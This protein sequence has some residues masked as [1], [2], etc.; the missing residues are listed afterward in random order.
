MPSPERL[1]ELASAR[2]PRI[3]LVAPFFIMPGPDVT[4]VLLIRHAQVPEGGIE[5][6]SA[7]TDLGKEQAEVL[8][9]YLASQP[10]AA[11]YASP[12]ARAIATATPVASRQGLQIE[13]LDGLRDLDNK[14]PR[15]ASP[16][17]A[18]L[19][20]FGEAEGKRR[21]ELMVRGGWSLDL[22]GGLLESSA[23]LRSRVTE[24]IDAIIAGHP[25]G[26]VAAISHGPTIAGYVGHVLGL[27][28]DF[29]FYPRLTSISVVLAQGERR[30]LQSLNA[31]PHFGTL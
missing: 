22:F 31:T 20:A 12:S 11:V 18:L 1:R 13:T 27:E 23:S 10:L 5:E 28:A 24:A 15:G 25:G 19:Q 16:Q 2:E 9:G 3:Q 6:D 30:M 29:A 4:E 7:L 17:E 21:F 14:L 8:A 26:R